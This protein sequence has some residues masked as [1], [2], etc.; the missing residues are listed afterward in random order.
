LHNSQ[1][2]AICSLSANFLF[3]FTNLVFLFLGYGVLSIALAN[4]FRA[5]F[6]NIYNIASMLR[7]LKRETIKMVFESAHFKKFIRIFSFTSTSKIITGLAYSVDMIVLARFIS[8]ALITMYEVN[9]RPISISSSLIGRHSVALMPLISHAKGKGDKNSIIDLINQQFKLYMYATL[10]VSLLFVFNHTNLIAAW[11]GPGQLVS[12]TLLYLFVAQFF[13]SLVATFMANVDYALGDIKVSSTYNI[14]RGIFY[15]VLM[16][17]AAKYY[18]IMGAVLGSLLVSLTA[19]FSFYYTR[20][21]KLGYLQLSLLTGLLKTW[22]FILPATVL[23]GWGFTKLVNGLIPAN[24]YF[25]RLLINSGVFTFFFFVLVM[26]VDVPV[27]TKV[28]KITGKYIAMPLSKL[29]RA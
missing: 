14:I 7:V 18:G 9:R 24:L 13:F 16:F 19:D 26:I 25:T 1:Q 3:L 15:G 11:T 23:G 17:F 21:Y 20:V 8:P 5:V 12:T 28:R 4:L 10:F 6:I 29:K 27:R 2:V 22:V